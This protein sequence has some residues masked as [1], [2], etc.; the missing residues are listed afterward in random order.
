MLVSSLITVLGLAFVVGI[1]YHYFQGQLM[2][3]LKKERSR[4]YFQRCG[5]CR[6]GLSEEAE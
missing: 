5:K 2:G 1:L 4:V 6:D 3:E